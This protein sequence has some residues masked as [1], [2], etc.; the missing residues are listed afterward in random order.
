M[1]NSSNKSHTFQIICM[2]VTGG[3]I[4]L[5]NAP[6]EIDYLGKALG[7]GIMTIAGGL[8]LIENYSQIKESINE[9]LIEPAKACKYNLKTKLTSEK[10]L[11]HDTLNFSY[12]H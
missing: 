8:L 12:M 7:T 11:F 2:G 10:T 3:L 9:N 5:I 1:N 4:S 6:K